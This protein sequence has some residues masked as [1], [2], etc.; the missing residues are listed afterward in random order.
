MNGSDFG[1]AVL[2]SG[3]GSNFQALLDRFH[4]R[5]DSPARVELLVASRPGIRALERARRAGVPTAVLPEEA[6]RADE[7]RFLLERLEEA[8]VH[9]VVLAGW[10]R[11]VPSEVVR[12]W[13]GRMVNVHPALLPA[14][15]GEGMYGMRVHRV[16]LEAG[17]RITGATVHFV[18]ERY[19]R[20][21]IIAQWPVPVREGDAPEELAARVLE[22]EH[23]VLPAVVEA[24]ARGRVELDGEGR[25]RWRDDWLAAE[26]FEMPG[27]QGT[28]EVVHAPAEDAPTADALLGRARGGE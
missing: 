28:H 24:I 22:V 2:A 8:E 17:V 3:S 7:A 11:L 4:G 13:W 10:L 6:D 25:C 14:F 5:K 1:V 18:D 20:G 12:A 16:V 27:G 21:P 23:R 19:D 15:G 26:R 9:L